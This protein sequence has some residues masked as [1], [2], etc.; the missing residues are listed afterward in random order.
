[1]PRFKKVWTK[2]QSAH[3]TGRLFVKNL[4]IASSH[5]RPPP[6]YVQ[7][8]ATKESLKL[9]VKSQA[10]AK[11]LKKVVPLKTVATSSNDVEISRPVRY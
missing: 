9:F 6:K 8:P 11:K 10:N 1:M 5:R 3:S 7:K 2:P 4:I